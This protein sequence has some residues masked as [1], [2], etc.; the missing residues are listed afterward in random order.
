MSTTITNQLAQFD[1]LMLDIS[2]GARNI[3]NPQRVIDRC[4]GGTGY[5][6]DPSHATWE[7]VRW[8]IATGRLSFDYVDHC[9]HDSTR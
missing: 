2:T 5:Q 7:D 1:A 6:A 4:C 3:E 9:V 8:H